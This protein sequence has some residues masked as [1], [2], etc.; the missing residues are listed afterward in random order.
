[1]KLIKLTQN[2]ETIIDDEDYEYLSQFK[3][4]YNSRYAMRNNLNIKGQKLLLHRIIINC[5][6]NKQVDHING[7]TL[8]NRKSNLRICSN[9]E[10][11]RNQKRQLN[12]TSIYKGVYWNKKDQRWKTQIGFNNKRIYLGNFKNEIEAAK[13][14]NKAALV[15]FKEFA[16]LNNV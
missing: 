6:T 9:I 12:K 1:M 10:N 5:P 11:R 16:K 13:A 3:W 14:Y 7:N 2:K 4:Y 8:D 15:Y